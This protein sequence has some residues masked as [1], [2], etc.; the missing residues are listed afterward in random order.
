[1]TLGAIAV[2][3]LIAPNFYSSSPLWATLACLLLVWR[4]GPFEWERE[5]GAASFGFFSLRVGSFIAIHALLI[6][7]A[8]FYGVVDSSVSFS[9]WSIAAM[10]LSVLFPTVLL[11]PLSRWKILACVYK[12]E[13]AAALVVLFTFFPRRILAT[14]WP[15]YGQMLGRVV[16]FLARPFVHG[17]TYVSAFTPTVQGPELDVTI[18]L[19]CSGI[20]GVELFDYLFALVV[21][22]DWNRLRKGRA[23]IAYFAGVA[24]VLLSN[25]VRIASF[26]VFGNRGFADVVVRFH[27]SAGSIFFSVV[28]VVYLSLIHR[29]LYS[30]SPK[31]TPENFST[32]YSGQDQ[33]RA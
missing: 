11:L 5:T 26:V 12:A 2:D 25:A 33:Q 6:S 24:A 30:G 10:K 31:N 9:G 20:S 16:F 15:W 22:L 19:A 28:F 17:L 4:R 29:Q 32:K 18:I 8:R 27:L 13:A 23:L 7:M 14:V 1:L 3:Y 21:F